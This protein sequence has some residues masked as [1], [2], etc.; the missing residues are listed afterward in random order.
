MP[1]DTRL[2]L[3][4]PRRCSEV[5]PPKTKPHCLNRLRKKTH[6]E[7]DAHT[8]YLP[9]MKVSCVTSGV[10]LSLQLPIVGSRGVPNIFCRCHVLS[11]TLQD[12]TAW[13]QLREQGLGPATTGSRCQLQRGVVARIQRRQTHIGRTVE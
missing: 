10:A 4:Y 7:R 3:H 6:L 8:T 5:P 12:P 1:H 2:H 11:E 9:A 13:I